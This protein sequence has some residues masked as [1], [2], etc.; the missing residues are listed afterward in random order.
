MICKKCGREYE[1][2]MLKCLWC[3]APNDSY[4]PPDPPERQD[5]S[6]ILDVQDRIDSTILRRMDKD[7]V[8]QE[9]S[10]AIKKKIAKHPAGDFMWCAAIL[11]SCTFLSALLAP[12]YVAFF[13]RSEI[14]KNHKLTK[15]VSAYITSIIV[16]KIIINGLANLARRIQNIHFFRKD[17]IE[18][19]N[20][21]LDAGVLLIHFL[22]CGYVAAFIIKRLTPDYEPSRYKAISATATKLSIPTTIAVSIA[23]IYFLRM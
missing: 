5:L 16:L 18:L 10:E 19:F 12:F 7:I 21:A 14:Y 9:S 13:H 22:L 6:D 15:F 2:D 20:Y 1:D 23:S 17:F 3:D 4:V 11:G 8:E